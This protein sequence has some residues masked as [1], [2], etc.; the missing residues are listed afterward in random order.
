MTNSKK[1][2][3]VYLIPNMKK[4]KENY[5][6]LEHIVR[7][8][9]RGHNVVVSCI[10]NEKIDLSWFPNMFNNSINI[11]DVNSLSEIDVLI[12][13]SWKTVIYSS[14]ISAKVKF[15]FVQN[16]NFHR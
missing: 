16:L 7:L 1:L 14:R 13:T 5:V 12:S 3:I 11:K 4:C 2:N 10:N 8:L 15:Y 6:V 9:H